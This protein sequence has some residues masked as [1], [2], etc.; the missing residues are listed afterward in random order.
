MRSPSPRLKAI[1]VCILCISISIVFYS[2]QAFAQTGARSKIRAALSAMG[3]EHK[4][5]ALNAMKMEGVAHQYF[6]EQSE[7][8]E[9]PWLVDY[10]E[11]SELCDIA[12]AKLSRTVRTQNILSPEGRTFTTRVAD[13]VAAYEFGGRFFPA[14]TLEAQNSEELLALTPERALLHAL[15]AS[16]LRLEKNVTMQGVNHHVLSCGWQ[17]KTLRLFLNA[18]TALPTA[19]ELVSEHPY[20]LFWG[21]WGE[22][23]TRVYFSTWMIEAGGIRYPRQ[24]DVERHG[25][26]WKS[27]TITQLVMNPPVAADS[28]DVP[29]EIREAFG[30]NKIA[31]DDLPLA[32][33]GKEPATELAKDIVKIPAGWDVALVRQS[34][35]VVIIE[36]PI[37]SGYSARVLAEAG[38]RFP[39]APIK[40]VISTSD[41]WPHV[42]G[43]REYVAR[44]V[45]IYALDLNRPLLE[46][47][48]AGL[49]KSYPDALAKQERKAK[50]Q[51]V[52]GKITLGAG[53][54]RL[55]LYPIRGES[56]ERMIMI[57]FPEHGLLYGSD[58]IQ[59]N[60][61]GS[62]FMTQYLS[63]LVDAVGRESL[64]VKTVFAM[65]SKA[66][67]WSEIIGAVD[68]AMVTAPVGNA[69]K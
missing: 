65:H 41:A 18:H 3:G 14:P 59:Q 30:K 29:L 38:R 33:R 39:G 26:P 2:A 21:I 43:I 4:L 62:F 60:R 54:N 22:V 16:D 27:I 45:P 63:E 61:D 36:A 37:S 28:F 23:T 25:L 20:D 11:F 51:I 10:Q 68:R 17:G 35:G 19:A 66:L 69:T 12:S 31:I 40:A 50:F 55:E 47:I 48:I 46:R 24:F 32:W 34:D 5:R 1:M 57:Y 9:G 49:R 56:S 8:P 44:G 6:L 64:A 53:E 15:Q 7:R 42:G 58:L 67:P 13:N 52:S